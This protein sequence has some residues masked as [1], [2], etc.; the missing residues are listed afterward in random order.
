MATDE[1]SYVRFL[2]TLF[3]GTDWALD[4]SSQ[5]GI[6]TTLRLTETTGTGP[7]RSLILKHARPTFGRGR[8]LSIKR[9]VRPLYISCLKECKS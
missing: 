2:R 3:S 9:Q 4:P 5:G 1:N 6:N 8:K 7:Y